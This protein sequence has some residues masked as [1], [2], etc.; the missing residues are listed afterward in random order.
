MAYGRAIM[1]CMKMS[2][3]ENLIPVGQKFGA[4]F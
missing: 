1:C 2:S 4:I 3:A